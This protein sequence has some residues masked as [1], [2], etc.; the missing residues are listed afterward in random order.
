MLILARFR[1][2]AVLL[3]SLAALAASFGC[4]G[5]Q[6]PTEENAFAGLSLTEYLALTR[7]AQAFR[8]STLYEPPRVD[9]GED[10][11]PGYELLS[12][13]PVTLD[14]TQNATDY[15]GFDT[16][17][18]IGLLD[19]G[20]RVYGARNCS[21]VDA[22]LPGPVRNMAW[23]AEARYLAA[24]GD[25]PDKVYVYD[26]AGCS[27]THVQ[28]LPGAVAAIAVSPTGDDLAVALADG[29]VLLG[30]ATGRLR[31]ALSTGSV[32]ALG[33]GPDGGVLFV[34]SAGGGVQLLNVH[35]NEIIQRFEA[36][37]GPFSS[38]RF[39][40][41]YLVLTA[42]DGRRTAWDLATHT[43]VPFSRK[44][45]QYQ[46]SDNQLRYKTWNGVLHLKPYAGRPEF[47][48]DYSP[49]HRLLRVLDLD[50]RNRFYDQD[51]GREVP[52]M[53]ASDWTAVS[54]N[55]KGNFCLDGRCYVLTDRA[56]QWDHDTLLC[57]H[58]PGL[59]HF[60]WWVK[61][62]RPE[63]F[64]PL[65]DHLPERESILEDEA[66]IWGPVVPPRDFP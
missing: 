11:P 52:A 63:E 61:S 66:V 16:A 39:Q 1:A 41:H 37:G 7:D 38:A 25:E 46:L 32:L 13:D 19:G 55:A 62:E 23:R 18:A 51:S 28:E 14:L 53:R 58:V 43:Q 17:L 35:N 31:P 5:R 20:L 40:D 48:V 22:N 24:M 54:T 57:R 6:M 50:G 44:L 9:V 2:V 36:K 34:V 47:N 12:R 15:Q 10:F 59:G 8:V 56:F 33:F 26:V 27:R 42:P 4:S 3:L 49:L 64:S 65:P 30:S 45:A 21:G 29:Q 60:L